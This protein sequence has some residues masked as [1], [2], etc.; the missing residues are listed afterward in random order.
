MASKGKPALKAKAAIL[1]Q[2]SPEYKLLFQKHAD[3]KMQPASLTKLM[4]ILLTL[5][6]LDAGKLKWSDQV[7]ISEN[8]AAIPGSNVELLAGEKYSLE[9]LFKAVI[10][11]SGNDAA[12]ALAEHISG[13]ESLFVKEMN[14]KA[15]ELGL[16]R[17]RFANSHGMTAEKHYST[18][19]D[20]AAIALE[21]LKREEVLK[22]SRLEHDYLEREKRPDYK[23]ENTNKLIG[24]MREIDG[25]KTGSST[26]AGYCLAASAARG[27]NKLLAVVLGAPGK[28]IR[29]DEVISLVKF[30]FAVLETT[31]KQELL[32]YSADI[33]AKQKKIAVIEL[34][35]H[36][37]FIEFLSSF[38]ADEDISYYF[39]HVF[40]K[41]KI[42]NQYILNGTTYV[43][44]QD[45]KLVS[46]IGKHI[47]KI[48][49]MDL[50]V[51]ATAGKVTKVFESFKNDF[52]ENLLV[53]V[54]NINSWF[55][56]SLPF[57][58]S[59]YFRSSTGNLNTRRLK[60]IKSKL[61][62]KLLEAMKKSYDIYRKKERLEL[63]LS[64]AKYLNV[65][66]PG[67]VEELKNRCKEKSIDRI[68]TNVPNRY[69]LAY[70]ND[71]RS[72]SE[73]TVT[74]LGSIRP[75]A[76][77]YLGFLEA[78]IHF[79]FNGKKKVKFVLLGAFRDDRYQGK[80]E[81]MINK[82]EHK[83]ISFK[84]FPGQ[85]WLSQT[86]IDRH[87]ADSD[88]ILSPIIR[89][90]TDRHT[91]E[92][93]GVTRASGID[94]D[95]FYYGKPL[96]VPGWYIPIFYLK[97]MYEQYNSYNH[98]NELIN[99]YMDDSVLKEKLNLVRNIKNKNPLEEI[100]R[101]F[102]ETVFY[103]NK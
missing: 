48:N 32:S 4:T 26:L 75:N 28:E 3:K 29:D 42:E 27:E 90:G 64:K 66:H 68:I 47:A 20:I 52:N 101:D 18:A 96:F 82:I 56:L 103:G 102:Y 100:R 41:Q 98:L 83:E 97:D 5:K 85:K 93:Y 35:S 12:V 30:G 13:K 61:L 94:F 16:S 86:D 1:I 65:F 92:I 99:R 67:M 7:L 60:F 31:G 70:E 80:V 54:H 55:N 33:R 8:A 71:L 59:Y 10:I 36:P 25:I 45:E 63:L 19:R 72:S 51:I 78:L 38:F 69:P 21:L 58:F 23:L 88:F 11:A 81:D 50:V 14:Q 73:L 84:T 89:L 76:R 44:D 22:Y 37:Q 2:V 87:M 79:Q 34:E 43:Q 62:L 24:R 49:Q 39:S 15:K 57:A 9:D 46:F 74:I 6:E 91:K 77:D 40:Y 53:V 95:A 17:T